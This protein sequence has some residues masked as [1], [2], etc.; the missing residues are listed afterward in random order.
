MLVHGDHPRAL[1]P[2]KVLGPLRARLRRLDTLPPGL[3]R[4]AELV[5]LFIEASVL[6]QG[7]L[8]A[9][10]EA[11][12]RSETWLSL[13]LELA[14][15]L[16]DSWDGVTA[17]GKASLALLESLERSPL[18]A[19]VT[20]KEPEGYAH[21]ALYPELYLEAAR[22]SRLAGSTRVVGVRSIGTGLACI[23]AAGLDASKP[24]LTVRPEGPPFERRLSPGP[25]LTRALEAVAR[26]D[27]V[28]I[29]DE[30]PGLSGSSFGA[31]ADFLEARSLPRER[32]HFFPSHEGAPGPMASGHQRARW[33]QVH[34]H[35][36][37]FNT[38]AARLA[39]WVEDLT[40][41]AIAPLE[42][43]SAGAWRRHLIPDPRD[44]PA[45]HVQQER[46]KYLLTTDQ[47]TFLL[48]FAGLGVPAEH[49]AHRARQL[50]EAGFTPPVTGLRHGFLVQPWL[51]PPRACLRP[52]A[53][54]LEHLGHYLGFRARTFPAPEPGRGAS[55]SQLLEMARYNTSQILGEES[56]RA[57][58]AWAVHLD[59]LEQAAR[60]VETDHKLQAWEWLELPGGQV[61]KTDAVDHHAGLDLVGCQDVA[62][63]IV[64][65]AVELDLSEP[66]LATQVERTCGHPVSPLLLCFY[67]PCYL[68][69]QCGHHTLAATALEAIAPDEAVRLHAAAARYA[70]RLK[71][72]LRR[73]PKK[74]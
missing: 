14:R 2:R 60:P 29:V 37:D 44:W 25:Q 16:G 64:G 33:A 39:A 1:D 45:V 71:D 18:P 36:A 28:A 38:C 62:W 8:D 13:P 31:V 48:R 59:A 72:A 6:A 43:I 56:A 41:P 61:L 15:R 70:L 53:M 40:G 42:D 22:A 35:T 69:F 11:G 23:V 24:P 9:A 19:Q 10:D 74:H 21:F 66:E 20:L 27:A 32:L 7:L 47:G 52:R 54:P 26:A 68:A 67:E 5:T 30:G 34:R 46:R 4:H 58:D 12:P 51:E 55:M 50:A 49:R 3:E 57:L 73:Q 17:T 63:D 65:A